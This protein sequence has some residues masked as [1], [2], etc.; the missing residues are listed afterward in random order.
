[1]TVPAFIFISGTNISAPESRPWLHEPFV[2]YKTYLF[3][4][5]N[6]TFFCQPS[7]PSPAQHSTEVVLSACATAVCWQNVP[8][9][10]IWINLSAAKQHPLHTNTHTH[11]T[12]L[13]TALFIW[14]PSKILRRQTRVT[15]DTEVI[16]TAWIVVVAPFRQPQYNALNHRR[17]ATNMRIRPALYGNV[18][19]R[20]ITIRRIKNGTRGRN[21][22]NSKEMKLVRVRRRSK[23]HQSYMV[24]ANHTC[25]HEWWL[26][27]NTFSYMRCED[28]TISVISWSH[29]WSA[30]SLEREMVDTVHFGCCVIAF[31][32]K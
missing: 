7:L 4:S 6:E 22:R 10:F 28:I 15:F 14:P 19:R 26:V 25:R 12:E 2:W 20:L 24:N 21:P 23:S 18:L 3:L 1:M 11:T 8:H 5:N 17:S 27:I 16:A 29:I 32:Q 9:L 30:A 31:V 13:N